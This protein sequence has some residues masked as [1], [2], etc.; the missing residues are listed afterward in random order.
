M[1]PA[2]GAVVVTGGAGG[3]GLAC[4]RA[5]AR[6]GRLLLQD[7][8]ERRLAAAQQA[9][10]SEGVEAQALAGDLCDPAH[11]AELAR[12]VA[13]ADGL[14]ALAHTAGISPTMADAR[15]VFEVDLV[16]TVRLIDALVPQLRPGAAAVL[17]A[18]QAGHFVAAAATPAIDAILDAPLDADAFD[19]LVAIAGDLAS[20]PGG[21][22]G[23]A[24]RGVH[25]LA[26][27]RAAEFGAAGA[28]I[29]SLSPGIIDTG[30]GRAERVAHAAATDAIVAKTA[31]GKRMGRP[32]E[33]A[34][35]VA[36]LCSDAASFVTGTD[37]LV[38]GGSTQQV[39]SGR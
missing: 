11:L 35:A 17:I 26:V 21:A 39:L 29:V 12:A 37:L 15:R 5:L 13:R 4:A 25:R 1:S 34:S 24:K 36:F 28:R 32:E 19:R 10:A 22:Y 18:S 7:L 20:S 23:L 6:D 30:M 33:I 9:L 16:A 3:I 8:D 27:A 31:L 2:G 38:D 14:R